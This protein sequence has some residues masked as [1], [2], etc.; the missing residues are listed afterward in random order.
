[1]CERA[2]VGGRGA[3]GRSVPAR[4]CAAAGSV[5]AGVCAACIIHRA[6]E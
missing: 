3:P 5:P 6:N 4:R 1:M 2:D